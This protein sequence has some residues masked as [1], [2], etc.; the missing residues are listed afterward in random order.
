[1]RT[2]ILCENEGDKKAHNGNKKNRM[3]EMMVIPVW[4]VDKKA[5]DKIEIGH[6]G[7]E[8][9]G[10]KNPFS[11]WPRRLENCVSRNTR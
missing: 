11:I 9:S 10:E 2:T 8:Q 1:M 5:K 4:V 6:Y 7:H 3:G